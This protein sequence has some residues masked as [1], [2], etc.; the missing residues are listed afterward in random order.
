MKKALV[1]GAAGYLGA[2]VCKALKKDGWEVV[3][4]GHKRHTLNPYIDRMIYGD[5]RDHNFM[6]DVMKWQTCDVV[7]HLAA[8][9][10]SGISFKEPTEFY[11]VNTGGACNVLNAM[12]NNGIKDRKSTRLNSSHVSESR[13]PSSA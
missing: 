6:L 1:T 2:H 4:L 7:V 5:V 3:G 10:E 12:W 9:I 8:R 13:M 11:S